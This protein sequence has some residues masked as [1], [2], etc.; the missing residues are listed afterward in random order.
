MIL[1]A[2]STTHLL[3]RG[4]WNG[5]DWSD[6]RHV[7]QSVPYH[8]VESSTLRRRRTSSMMNGSELERTEGRELDASYHSVLNEHEGHVI[9]W[10]LFR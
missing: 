10:I 6:V 4:S 1:P 2:I 9:A 5:S 7:I 3:L 8:F